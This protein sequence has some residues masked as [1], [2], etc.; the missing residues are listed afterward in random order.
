[1]TTNRDDE[2]RAELLGCPFCGSPPTVANIK[3]HSHKDGIAAFMPDHPGS[4]YVEC[5]CGAGL[6]DATEKKVRERWNT[7]SPADGVVRAALEQAAVSFEELE[8]VFR[9]EGFAKIAALAGKY[10]ENARAAL[11]STGAGK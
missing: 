6:I 1:M 8:V 11:Q 10:R 2:G 5:S 3:P 4:S 7:R 9:E